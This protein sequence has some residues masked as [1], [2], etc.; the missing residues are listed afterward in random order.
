MSRAMICCP[1]RL[2]G[3][4][5]AGELF[6][7]NCRVSTARWQATV[8]IPSFPACFWMSRSLTIGFGGGNRHPAGESGVFSRPSLLPY[9][10]TN[11]S[12]LS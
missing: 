12:T 7:S 8:G 3:C 9:M 5:F 11:I 10:P 1:V 4:N 2:P 6:Q